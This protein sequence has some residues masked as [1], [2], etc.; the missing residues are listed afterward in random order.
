MIERFSQFPR[1][2]AAR[3]RTVRFG[4][5]PALLAHPDWKAPAPTV[6]WLHGRT[7]T[8][9]LDPGRYLRWLRAGIAAC[10]IDLPGHGERREPELER[11]E[12]AMDVLNLLLP[13]IDWVV[14]HLADPALGGVFDLDRLAI[15]GMSLGGMAA[16][17]RLCDPHSFVC[18]T[19][20]ATTGWLRGLYLDQT[21]PSRWPVTHDPDRVRP[22]DAA[23]H[24]LGFRPVPLQVLHSHA[25]RVIPFAVQEAFI[26]RLADQYRAR[27]AD[28]TMIEF[29]NWA[30]TG[31]PDEHSGF[32]KVANEAKNLQV[33]F[34][35]RHLRPT[36]PANDL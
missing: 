18:A 9:E 6:L 4:H 20:E 22:V 29:R 35:S 2:L 11:S 15:G 13:E 14:E 31:A 23:E 8:K 24:L 34:L 28:A 12:S 5:V 33:E 17:R 26:S 25:D 27:D 30:T 1:A 3:A 10:A 32:G 19:V 7:V 36:R 21:W 16:L